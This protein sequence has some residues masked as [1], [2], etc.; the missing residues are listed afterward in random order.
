[1]HKA[2]GSE[3]AEVIVLLGDAEPD[4]RLL[5]TALTR[6]RDRAELITPS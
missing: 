4:G 5:Y 2:Q 3:A 1:V 6:A